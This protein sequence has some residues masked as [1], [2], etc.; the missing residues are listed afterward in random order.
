MPIFFPFSANA[1][2]GLERDGDGEKKPPLFPAPAL[3]RLNFL[4]HLCTLLWP[5]QAKVLHTLLCLE[6]P[7]ERAIKQE[8]NS[9]V[10][11]C[12]LCVLCSESGHY[13]VNILA[14][15]AWRFCRAG[16][17]SG[18]ATKFAREA[19]ENERR[20]R[21]KN[22]NQV[23]SAPISSRFLCSR[24]PLLLS[25]PNQN[26]HATQARLTSFIPMLPPLSCQSPNN[27]ER[28]RGSTK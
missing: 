8:N 20:S 6:T 25:A 9:F 15:V 22:K 13:T 3:L 12:L 14:C 4:P 21:E 24:P 18:V 23:A 17:R 10:F 5:Q 7:S 27:R 19:R 16:R 11:F 1:E 28:S 2:P 26:R